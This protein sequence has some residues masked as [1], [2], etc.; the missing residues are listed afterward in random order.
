VNRRKVFQYIGLAICMLPFSG[1]TAETVTMGS[2]KSKTRPNIVFI[3]ADDMGY[4]DPGCYN[5]ESKIPTPNMDRMASEGIRFTDTHSPSSVCTPTRY[6]ILTGRYAWR[7]EL[8]RG[9]LWSWDR[10]LIEKDRLTVAD[11]LKQQGYSTACIGKWHLGWDWPTTDGSQINDQLKI[12]QYNVKVRSAFAQKVDFTQPLKGGPVEHGFDYYFGDDVPNFPPYCFIEN[13]RVVKMPTESKPSTMFGAPGPMRPGWKLGDVM[14]TLTEKATE[15]IRNHTLR[16]PDK[17]FFL[18]FSLTAPHTPIV[19]TAEFTGKS[20]AGRY[21]DY[22]YQVDWTIGKVLEA[23]KKQGLEDNTLVI[24]TSDNGS[25]ARDGTN[26]SGQVGSVKKFGHNPSGKL[27]GRKTDAWE[28][29]HR[30]PF[31]AR[32]PGHIKP[33]SL[34]H[35]TVCLADFM[36]TIASVVNVQLPDTAAEDSYNILPALKGQ[37]YPRPI[38]EA[39]VHHSISGL[40]CIRKGKWK[41]IDGV[42]SGGSSGKGDGL[43]GQLYDMD[44]D[45]AE[46]NNLYESP[47]HQSI[48]QE[49]KALLEQYKT[50]THSHP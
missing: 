6:G 47:D 14:P 5:P 34:S 7:T 21:G 12:G 16:S 13:D 35:E 11:M 19:P 45:L 24:V 15:Y 46:S 49:L 31:I 20:Q 25:P 40:F 18:Y 33:T 39:T 26:D 3:L 32:W 30:V 42:G 17:P 10:P 22:V 29:G 1:C 2:E 36:S 50:Q 48:I 9:V 41:Y 27:R 8:K 28:G 38:R 44:I 43:P 23:L 4:G 37:K